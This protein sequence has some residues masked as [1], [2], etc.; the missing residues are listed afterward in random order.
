M[1]PGAGKPK[2]S[3]FEREVC[4]DLSIWLSHG[5]REDVFWRSS[6]SGGRATVALKRDVKLHAQAGDISAITA[7]GEYFL[8][9]FFIECKSYR[10]LNVF[11]SIVNGAGRLCRFWQKA[12]TEA[13]KYGKHPV[14]VAHQNRRPTICLINETCMPVF[15]LEVHNAIAYVPHWSCYIL[16]FECFLREAQVPAEDVYIKRQRVRL[17]G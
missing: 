13:A 14:L 4:R 1:R 3:A 6:L 15:A 10:D 17:T 16:L 11:S 12:V 2:G 8:R 9:H 5:E 7:L